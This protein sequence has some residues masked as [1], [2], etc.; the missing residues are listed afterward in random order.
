MREI[1]YETGFLLEHAVQE[2][3]ETIWAYEDHGGYGA[4]RK[5]LGEMRPQEV[6]AEVKES[7]L[8]GRGGAGFPAGVKWGFLPKDSDK[9]VYLLVNADE[10]EPGTFKDRVFL[11]LDPHL[12]LEGAIITAY[13]IGAHVAYVY[14][15]GEFANQAR[16]LER[17]IV[18]A[19]A[20]GYLGADILGSGFDLEV[21]VH[22][23]AG[24]YICGEE[25]GLIESLEGKR[26]F[27]RLKPPYPAS[28]GVFGC[29]T[30]V[31]NVETLSS[32]PHIVEKGAEWFRGYGTAESAGTRVVGVS[33]HVKRP[34]IYELPMGVPLVELLETYCG[35]VRSGYSLKAVVP[36]GS[37]VPVLRADEIDGVNLDFESCAAA[38]TMLGSGG[39]IVMDDSVCMVD[40]ALNLARFYAHESCGQCTPCREGCW[41]MAGILER[42]EAG[43]GRA[44]DVDLLLD[45]CDNMLFKTV[46]PLGD[47]AAMPI[48]SYVRK[49]RS[50]FERHAAEGRCPI[51]KDKSIKVPE[52]A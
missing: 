40:T 50:E 47:A 17:A 13:A 22:R 49:F 48:E 44:E 9:P 12:L 26:G 16:R 5:A 25:T 46:C 28:V 18:E 34:G 37:S 6:T 23:G 45:I 7:G 11:E 51:A 20:G 43:G 32:V 35:G 30:I 19:H 39:V 10:S 36:G 1:I 42:L 31:N 21:H 38:G 4:L 14:I 8:R 52:N 29:P 2:G 24:A 15:R 41:W 27:P 33:G 3:S